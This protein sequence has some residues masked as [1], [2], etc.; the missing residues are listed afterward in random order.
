MEREE[1]TKV[2]VAR[3]NLLSFC[4]FSSVNRLIGGGGGG[5]TILMV[6]LVMANLI[7]G[8]V[9]G[10]VAIKSATTKCLL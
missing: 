6:A 3:V 4:F 10:F 7:L 1:K 5:F 9:M 8:L 2:E